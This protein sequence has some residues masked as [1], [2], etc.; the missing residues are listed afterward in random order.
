MYSTTVEVPSYNNYHTRIFSLVSCAWLNISWNSEKNNDYRK[1]QVFPGLLTW[2]DGGR[3]L[4]DRFIS[5]DGTIGIYSIYLNW[6][7]YWSEIAPLD[8]WHCQKIEPDKLFSS[9]S[10]QYIC[11]ERKILKQIWMLLTYKKSSARQKISCCELVAFSL[12]RERQKC[13]LCEKI[14]EGSH[15]INKIPKPSPFILETI[16]SGT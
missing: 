1:E 6:E 11:S 8:S 4:N 9:S 10:A 12:S 7:F 5:H 15:T 14:R 13:D 16:S 2:T 3:G